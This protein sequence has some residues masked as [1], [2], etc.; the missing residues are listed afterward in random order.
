MDD[1][2]SQATKY[3]SNAFSFLLDLLGKKVD[4]PV[5][6]MYK[7]RFPYHDIGA[8]DNRGTVV[9]NVKNGGR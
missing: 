5:V 1:N 9:F 4:H 7:K 3:P 6:Q 2:H 8:D